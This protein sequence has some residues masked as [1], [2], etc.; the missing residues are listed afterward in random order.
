M[1]S[2]FIT[3][4]VVWYIVF[5]FSTT[6][7]EAAHSFVSSYG[8]DHTARLGGQATLNPMPHIRQ[9]PF[10]MVIAPILTFL[11]SHGEYLLG[12]ASAPYNMY[13][14]ARYPKRAFWMSLAGPLSHLPLLILSFLGM[15]MGLRTGFF[16]PGFGM[17]SP[18]LYPV[19]PAAPGNLGWALAVLC[20]IAFRLNLILFVFNLLPLP[21]LDGSE[22]WY[23]FMKKE[24]TRLRVRHQMA[25]YGMAG[26]M[27][28]W[29]V[30]PR[31]FGPVARVLV[32]NL[33]WGL[34]FGMY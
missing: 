29:Y 19:E 17:D 32:V 10:G 33:L 22:L 28:A 3:G 13:W 4:F 11:L 20:N 30:F 7:H 15:Y 9:S 14:A 23:L 24:E 34:P 6:F 8:G 31:V 18:M 16:A 25:Q 27:L 21:P 2:S 1:D 12:W 5:L 26:L